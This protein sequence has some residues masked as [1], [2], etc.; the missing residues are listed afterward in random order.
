M[1]SPVVLI[2]VAALSTLGVVIGAWLTLRTTDRDVRIAART[3]AAQGTWAALTLSEV[4]SKRAGVNSLV[5]DSIGALGQKIMSSGILPGRTRMELEAALS[6]A[7]FRG[8]SALALFVGS[9]LLLMAFMPLLGWMLANWLG[10]DSL[11]RMG[12]VGGFGVFGMIAPDYIVRRIRKGY[13][14]RLESGMPDALDL[15][16]IC[17]QAGLSLEPAMTRVAHELR[18]ARPEVAQ[19][20]ELTVRELEILSEA[21]VALTNMGRRTGLETLKRLGSTLIQTMQYGTPLTEALRSL[22]AELRQMALTRFEERAARLPVLLTLPM[23]LFI[24]PCIFIVVGGPAGIQVARG[25]SK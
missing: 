20:L 6:A 7:G 25:M 17:A 9:K 23:I 1:I 13:L 19:E 21:A 16:T 18:H 12:M 3:A 8:P 4:K 24:L 10:F 11:S 2:A 15:L 5:Q 22:S 14:K